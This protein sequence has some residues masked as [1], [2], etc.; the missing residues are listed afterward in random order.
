[1]E[2]EL[3]TSQGQVLCSNAL[4]EWINVPIPAKLIFPVFVS[5]PG[6]LFPF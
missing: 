6:I 1:M 5:V 3:F 4:D 2:V